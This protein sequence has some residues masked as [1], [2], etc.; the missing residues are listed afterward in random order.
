MAEKPPVN[1]ATLQRWTPQRLARLKNQERALELRSKGYDWEEIRAELKLPTVAQ[2]MYLVK[3]GL[4]RRIAQ[5]AEDLRRLEERKL[6]RAEKELV[7]LFTDERVLMKRDPVTGKVCLNEDG[8]PIVLTTST[9]RTVPI[10]TPGVKVNAIDTYLRLSARR[11][12]LRGLNAP[13]KVAHTDAAGNDLN[14][15]AIAAMDHTT[16]QALAAGIVE[17]MKAKVEMDA[18]LEK[19]KV[20]P[21]PVLEAD[22]NFDAIDAEI[23][24]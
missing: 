21:Q 10:V 9:G 6:D 13:S 2:V 20:K 22:P 11:S 14:S 5:P 3:R 24:E 4:E 18:R 15:A 8:T 16:T 23:A 1:L 12:E 17:Q 7:K 19:L